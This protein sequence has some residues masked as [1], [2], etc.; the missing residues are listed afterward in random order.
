[1]GTGGWKE[2]ARKEVLD[3]R[4]GLLLS[5]LNLEWGWGSSLL[6]GIRCFVLISARQC[7]DMSLSG[8]LPLSLHRLPHCDS[9]PDSKGGPRGSE[10][11]TYTAYQIRARNL[12]RRRV[13][14][15]VPAFLT[16]DAY[17]IAY[18]KYHMSGSLFWWCIFI[19]TQHN[20]CRHSPVQESTSW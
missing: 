19:V 4:G 15:L 8:T 1:M 2:L 7:Y 20:Y 9:S 10:A 13:L 17:S 3:R 18:D 16:D 12:L 6:V 11:A 5:R 14:S